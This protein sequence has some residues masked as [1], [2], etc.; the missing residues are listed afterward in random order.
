M[1][2]IKQALLSVSDK[3]GLLDLAV[4]LQNAGAAL[5]STGGTARA[6]TQ[7]GLTVTEVSDYTGS[8]ELL[9]GRVKSLH[10]KIHAGLLYR[11]DDPEHQKQMDALKWAAIDMVVVNLYPFEKV[12]A[13]E[14]AAMALALENIDIGGPCLLRAAAKNHAHVAVL[15]EPSDYS[16]IIKE[17]IE[18]QGGIGL[19]TLKGLALKAFARTSAYDAAIRDY[20]ASQSLRLVP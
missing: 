16:L 8:P 9:D 5:I 15:S 1:L 17:M 6:L 19:N 13:Q 11:R 4:F 2:F 18:N 10:P 7:G 20:L 3:T 12:V 14:G